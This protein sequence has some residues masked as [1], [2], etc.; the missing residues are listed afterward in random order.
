MTRA[1]HYSLHYKC[2][3]LFI[4]YFFHFFLYLFISYF[5]SDFSVAFCV[6]QTTRKPNV[7]RHTT[8]T[9]KTPIFHSHAT[10]EQ[11][12]NKN[13]IIVVPDKVNKR[14]KECN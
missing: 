1:N 14:N 12:D 6:A 11:F 3:D 5:K 9:T 10:A 13:K 2:C 4:C 8:H 7:Q